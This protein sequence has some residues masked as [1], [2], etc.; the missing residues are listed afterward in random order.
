MIGIIPK[1]TKKTPEWQNIGIYV[2]LGLLVALI[3][4]YALIFYFESK[5]STKLS[6]LEEKIAQVGTK[7]E[8]D[9][10]VQILLAGRRIDDFFGILQQHRKSSSLFRFLEENCHPEVQFVI[11]DLA[12]VDNLVNISARTPTFE[13]LGQQ[14]NILQ[15][16]DL[17]ESV[18]LNSVGV[19]DSGMTEFTLSLLFDPTIFQ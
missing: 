13:T 4:G 8:K 3:L 2:A 19:G 11:M 10:E 15:A 9:T 18:A 16:Q 6:E 7:E 1:R 5:A 14:I 17:V 12:P